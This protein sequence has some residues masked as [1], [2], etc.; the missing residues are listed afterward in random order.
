VLSD[1]VQRCGVV[2]VGP[3]VRADGTWRV[4]VGSVSRTLNDTEDELDR[5]IVVAAPLLV[6][7]VT[8]GS[9]ILA[10]AALRPV[11]RMR[12]DVSTLADR[13]LRGQ[14]REPDD[15]AELA[16]LARTFNELLRRL[17]VSLDRQEG[18]VIDAGHELRTPLAILSVELELA[19]RPDRSAAALRE[20]VGHAR[21][22]VARLN[23][24]CE[25]LLLL[26]ETASDHA[27]GPATRDGL[28]PG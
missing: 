17:H 5:V 18:L 13:D 4:V 25:D 11:E 16:A 26:A 28:E 12:R 22:E 10:G 20:A 19:D 3:V 6:I 14:L 21:V 15:V 9:W 8:A 23:R 27:P 2:I 7:V 24:I 1:R